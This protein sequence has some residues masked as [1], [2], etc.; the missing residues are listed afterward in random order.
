MSSGLVPPSG[1]LWL[2]IVGKHLQ[3]ELELL[4]PHIAQIGMKWANPQP[5]IM[6]HLI[7]ETG[8]G[9]LSPYVDNVYELYDEGLKWLP[10]RGMP[11]AVYKGLGFIGYGG[12]LERTPSRHR[13]WHW[14]QLELDRHPTTEEDLPRISGVVSISVAARTEFSRGYRGYDFRACELSYSKLGN[15]ILSSH[16]GVKIGSDLTKWSFGTTHEFTA[17]LSDAEKQAIGVYIDTSGGGLTWEDLQTPWKD[18]TTPWQDLGAGA[19]LRVMARQTA[20][21]KG[22]MGFYRSDGSLIGARRFKACHQVTPGSSYV[23]AGEQVAPSADGARVYAEALTGFGDGAGESV[24]AI[25]LLFEAKPKA[26]LPQ[27]K[28]WLAPDEIDAPKAPVASQSF[29]TELRLTKR[30]RVKVLLSFA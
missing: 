11:I 30:T 5:R 29:E 10:V 8:L 4:R 28:L 18:I 12:V 20:Q 9:M 27:G 23:V 13:K 7:E 15:S 17:T 26:H 19:A 24:S 25:S 3:A 14:D 6:P 22:Y 1:E 2:K 16:S 21:Q